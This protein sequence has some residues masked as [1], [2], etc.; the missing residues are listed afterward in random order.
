MQK[1]KKLY[2]YTVLPRALFMLCSWVLLCA[3]VVSCATSSPAIRAG[4][5]KAE[6]SVAQNEGVVFGRFLKQSAVKNFTVSVV[7]KNTDTR[8]RYAF[9]FVEGDEQSVLLET[10]PAGSYIVDTI[11]YIGLK[12]QVV[13][14]L[15]FDV[16]P[17]QYKRAFTLGA[18]ECLYLGDFVCLIK[19]SPND[20]SA[21][22]SFRFPENKYGETMQTIQKKYPFTSSMIFISNMM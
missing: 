8:K 9:Y 17:E 13:A 14:K 20:K 22:W 15:N 2:A 5:E 3:G 18:N 6:R 11:E 4:I 1:N 7:L 16:P 21:H 10:L 12:D 19:L